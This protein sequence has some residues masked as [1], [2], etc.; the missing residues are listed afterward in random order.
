VAYFLQASA[1][2]MNFCD[3]LKTLAAGLSTVQGS[4][5]WNDLLNFLTNIVTKDV[6]IDYA[7][8]TAA[9]ILSLCSEGGAQVSSS[10]TKAKDS[11][12]LTCTMT[13]A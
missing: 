8:P 7:E 4:T 10:L 6:F 2:F 12:G 5:Q 9:A 3:D 13:V 11:S 1:G